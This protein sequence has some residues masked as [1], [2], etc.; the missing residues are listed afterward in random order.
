MADFPAKVST[1]TS[2]P[3]SQSGVDRLRSMVS[4]YVSTD[5]DFLRTIPAVL[6]LIEIVLGLVVWA[7]IAASTYTN[8]PAYGWVMF[9][10]VI[11][12]LLTILVFLML[13]FRARERMDFLPWP[14]ALLIFF[15][16]ATILYLTAF[17]TNA[18]SVGNKHQA[19]SAFFAIVVTLVYGA[20]T[21]FALLAWRQD[22][23]NAASSTVPV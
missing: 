5:L 20:S 15:G 17:I 9:V 23:G 16:G 2:S 19:A 6:M 13:L 4:Q 10:S 12:W 14:L 7:L 11:L 8:I 21:F 18:A 22:G 3:P 1:E